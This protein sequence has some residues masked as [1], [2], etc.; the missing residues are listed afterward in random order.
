M[1]VALQTRFVPH[2]HLGMAVKP[3]SLKYLPLGRNRMFTHI[4]SPRYLAS[5]QNLD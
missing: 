4:P 5:R 2:I 1:F 3:L